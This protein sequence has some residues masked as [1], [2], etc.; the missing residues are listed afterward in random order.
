[1]KGVYQI[2]NTQNNKL[3]IGSSVNIDKRRRQHFTDLKNNQHH[4][5]HLQR[6]YN[7]CNDCLVFEFLEPA[8]NP[9]VKEQELINSV[10]P[11][12]NFKLSTNKGWNSKCN[13]YTEKGKFIKTFN[14]IEEAA[15]ELNIHVS[16]IIR[17]NKRNHASKFG[18]VFRTFKNVHT[19]PTNDLILD[20]FPVKIH[21]SKY[22]Y[23]AYDVYTGTTYSFN[24]LT[25]LNNMFKVY[26][27]SYLKTGKLFMSR[28]WLAKK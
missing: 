20:P 18:R 3:Y 12:Y 17:A 14:S 8:E 11:A 10:K 28:Y 22:T 7:K 13:Y 27:G 9:T 23:I 25:A 21:R 19:A 24:K 26:C 15:K 1:M 4:N 5:I 2:R 16:T 6:S